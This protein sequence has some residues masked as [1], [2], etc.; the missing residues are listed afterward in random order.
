MKQIYNE[1]MVGGE[2]EGGGGGRRQHE[3]EVRIRG[4]SSATTFSLSADVSLGV[5]VQADY[6]NANSAPALNW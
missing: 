2:R 6:F 3:T 1:K 4:E 5:N